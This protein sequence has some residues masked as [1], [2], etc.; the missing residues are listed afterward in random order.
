LLP[1][2]CLLGI[3]P[4]KTEKRPS[5]LQFILQGPVGTDSASGSGR[6][7]NTRKMTI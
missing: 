2:A 6:L 3:S 4:P 7:K 5:Q 1:I